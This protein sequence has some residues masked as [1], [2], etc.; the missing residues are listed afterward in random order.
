MKID[1]LTSVHLDR[2]NGPAHHVLE[3][4]RAFHR[5][6][7]TL[8]LIHP[9]ASLAPQPSRGEFGQ[10]SRWF[11]RMRGGRR[12]YHFLIGR[13]IRKRYER[14]LP[15]I[16]YMR[17]S[18]SERFVDAIRPL[19]MPKVLEVNGLMSLG[20]PPFHRLVN[21]VDLVL[22]D[23]E[24]MAEKLCR[25]TGLP[26]ARAAVHLSPGVDA[27]HFRPM[28]PIACRRTL[29]LGAERVV[30]LHVSGFQ[31]HHDFA[32]LTAAFR[33]LREQDRRYLLVLLGAGPRHDEIRASVADLVAS[34]GVLMPGMVPTTLLPT[35][36]GAADVCINL[37]T[38]ANLQAGNLRAFKL[39]E[40]AACAR[41]TVEAIDA[42]LPVASWASSCLGL[43][44]AESVKDVVQAID[45]IRQQPQA[46][47]ERCAAG[48]L[49][50]ENNRDWTAATRTTLGAIDAR[51][52]MNGSSTVVPEKP[53]PY[54]QY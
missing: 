13:L 32:T 1:Y 53:A 25:E 50:V 5:L 9:S 11:P 45:Q 29:G 36:I 21:L 14:E 35:Y 2:S 22:L 30:V 7:H 51:L 24:E 15:D 16:L 3:T 17:F 44:P 37:F 20:N 4:S 10:T 48:R 12:L 18:P 33:T 31:P 8:E 52:K 28:D 34:G 40:Y 19:K 38:M 39:Y 23:S 41:P 49:F 6:G 46:W 26:P 54:T 47:Q 27:E 42:R 43:V